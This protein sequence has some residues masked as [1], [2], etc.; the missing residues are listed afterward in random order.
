MVAVPLPRLVEAHDKE[1][2]LVQPYQHLLSVISPRDGVAQRGGETI[3][4]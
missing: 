3:E 4:D 1:V 2:G